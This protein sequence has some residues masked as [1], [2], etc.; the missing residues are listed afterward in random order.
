[1]KVR[2]RFCAV[3]ATSVRP[4]RATR[5]QIEKSG[6]VMGTGHSGRQVGAAATIMPPA[7]AP[8]RWGAIATSAR[9]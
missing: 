6:E 2:A 7:R 4:R 8:A 9:P 1:M 3:L 5:G